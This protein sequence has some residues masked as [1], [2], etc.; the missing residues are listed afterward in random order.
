MTILNDQEIGY[1]ID[2]D[3]IVDQDILYWYAI[4]TSLLYSVFK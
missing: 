4:K 3:I 1:N 2:W